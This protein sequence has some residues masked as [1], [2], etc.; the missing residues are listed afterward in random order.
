MPGTRVA[1][2]VR[3]DQIVRA[4]FDLAGR[5]GLRAITIRDV[6]RVGEMSTGLVIFHFGTKERLVLAL[7][8]WILETTVSLVVSPAIEAIADPMDRLV[9]LIQQEMARV[10]R[11]PKR[12]RV[13]F[14]FW[15]EGASSRA[16]RT[17]MQRDLDRYRAEFRPFVDAAVAAHPERFQHADASSL[18]TIV[19]SVIKGCALQ[20]LIEPRLDVDA[21]LVAAESFLAPTLPSPAESSAM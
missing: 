21:L 12:N 8:D 14:E 11:E 16:V 18:T 6:A 1:E 13:F 20:S 17:K 5:G 3:R 2:A 7:L 4:A 19:V 10:W 15:S 9:A